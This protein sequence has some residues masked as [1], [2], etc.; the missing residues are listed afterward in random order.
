LTLS[1]SANG[2]PTLNELAFNWDY[3]APPAATGGVPL[4]T[5]P[6]GFG[7][8]GAGG[9]YSG[10]GSPVPE[11]IFDNGIRRGWVMQSVGTPGTGKLPGPGGMPS[12]P[13]TKKQAAGLALLGG[14]WGIGIALQPIGKLLL[15]LRSVL[16]FPTI[17]G[18]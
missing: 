2:V 7:T 5:D 4:L 8:F 11:V 17:G 6:G 18:S 10:T 9:S 12:Q 1:A 13:L 14:M 15:A 16:P 3:V